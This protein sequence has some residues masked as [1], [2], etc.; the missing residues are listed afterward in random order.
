M[1]DKYDFVIVDT[2]PML[3]VTDPS[4]VAPRVD[5]VLLVLRL[6]KHARDAASQ[7]IEVLNSLGAVFWA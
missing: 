5:A 7:S 1:R 6:T 4:V 2:P 3:A